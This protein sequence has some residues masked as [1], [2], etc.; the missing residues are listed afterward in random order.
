MGAVGIRVIGDVVA[1][2]IMECNALWVTSREVVDAINNF[3]WHWHCS[4]SIS[5]DDASSLQAEK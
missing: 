5:C 4:E 3:H 1:V 2:T